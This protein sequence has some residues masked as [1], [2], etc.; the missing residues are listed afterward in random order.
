MKYL[1]IAEKPSLM[2]E[3]KACYKRHET[4]IVRKVGEIYFISL[5]GHLCRNYKPNEYSEWEDKKWYEID[6]PIVPTVWKLKGDT[7]TGK[8]EILKQVKDNYSRYDGIIVGTDSDVEGYGIYYNLAR[9][10]NLTKMKTL[11][12]IEHSLTDAEIKKSLLSMTDFYKDPVHQRNIYAYVLRS[13]A[14]W[15][16]G[17]NATMIA[18][19]K[20]GTLMAVGRVKSPTLKLV[21]DNSKAIDEFKP[22]T[23][24]TLE[25]QYDTFS[26]HLLN[27]EGHLATFKDQNEIPS[28]VPKK[29]E[30]TKKDVKRVRTHAPKL[31]DLGAIQVEAGAMYGY[32]PSKTLELVQSLYEKHKIIS[33]PRTACRYI[34]SEKAKELPQMLSFVSVFDDLAPFLQKIT[35]EDILRVQSDKEVV[36]DKEIEKESHDALLPTSVKPVL[37]ALTEEERNICY[38]IYKRLLMQFLP[39]L[40]EEKTSLLIKHGN[41][42]FLSSGKVTLNPGWRVLFKGGR[43]LELPNVKEGETVLAN[44]FVSLQ[45]V[46]KPPKRLTESSL[47]EAMIRIANTI[48]DKELRKS[49]ADSKGIGTPATRAKIVADIIKLGYVKKEKGQLFITDLGKEYI[50]FLNDINIVSPIFAA[51]MD[52]KIKE[53]M[54]G[55]ADFKNTYE[56]ILKSLQLTCNELVKKPETKRSKPSKN[57]DYLDIECPICGK[58]TLVL[59]DYGVFCD[60]K[61]LK[62]FK[63]TGL[64]KV[65]TD[66]E[67]IKLL[68]QGRLEKCSGFVSKKGN[69]FSVDVVI[70]DGMIK[71]DFK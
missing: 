38:M 31:Y 45:K 39:P 5:V 42:S 71:L 10:L 62:L 51:K 52:T 44:E 55:E 14:D 56:E 33:Y 65:F 22:Q 8:G 27:E 41:Y 67:L 4:E 54:R 11:R 69:A 43:E 16:F 61:N 46:T 18:T 47:L 28:D 59:N 35:K 23:Y 1:F 37:S 2:R 21:Y 25:A 29:G 32:S 48:K 7:G 70:R 13:R 40:E 57:T 49:L 17:M 60:C 36:N 3:V 9:Y 68:K 66:R 53:V 24:Y 63:K 6:Y 50:E 26:S 64:K 30:I 58:K 34:S 12:F 20:K 15:L 19:N